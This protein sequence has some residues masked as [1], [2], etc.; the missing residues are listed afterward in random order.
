MTDGMRKT[1]L[2]VLTKSINRFFL[3]INRA[4]IHMWKLFKAH[5][6]PEAFAKPGLTIF[7]EQNIYAPDS[8][9]IRGGA[10]VTKQA[11]TPL[12]RGSDMAAPCPTGTR[13]QSEG[14]AHSPQ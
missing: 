1:E 10:A 9:L 7:C 6:F 5:R 3:L 8:V 11:A 2:D 12:G 4:R 13:C 14:K